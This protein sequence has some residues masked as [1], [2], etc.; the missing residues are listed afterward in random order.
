MNTYA[1]RGEGVAELVEILTDP[2]NAK[3]VPDLAEKLKVIV[4]GKWKGHSVLANG[5]VWLPEKKTAT[6]LAEA[7]GEEVR[8]A[9]FGAVKTS[10]FFSKGQKSSW[11]AR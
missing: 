9:S 1:D 2:A 5:N 10:K 6:K 7:M 8:P 4:K 11:I 3:K